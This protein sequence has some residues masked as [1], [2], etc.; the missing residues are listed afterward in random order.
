MGMKLYELIEELTKGGLDGINTRRQFQNYPDALA[1]ELTPSAQKA[2]Y[3]MDHRSYSAGGVI[4]TFVKQEF[5]DEGIGF[6]FPA[7]ND[8][9]VKW[10]FPEKEFVPPSKL[11]K[12]C[13]YEGGG[14]DYP[15]PVPLVYEIDPPYRDQGSI[16]EGEE[17]AVSGQGFVSGRT[18]V[19]LVAKATGPKLELVPVY[20]GVEGTF[21]CGHLYVA[22][23]KKPAAVNQDEPYAINVIVSTGTDGSGNAVEWTL[24]VRKVNGT[25]LEFVLK[26]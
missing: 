9:F 26:K 11:P 21:R 7:W 1:K 2:L 5:V 13:Q 19:E 8:W 12:D 3:S 6:Q 10:P 24:P 14:Q 15:E 4:A 22:F 16:K 18:R 20:S 17:I 25:E 23:A